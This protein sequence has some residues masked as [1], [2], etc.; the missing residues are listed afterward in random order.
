MGK[1]IKDENLKL[2]IIVNGD[3]GLKELGELN[4]ATR[5]LKDETKDMKAESAKL[6]AAG[7]KNLRNTID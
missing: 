5:K 3:Q 1:V 2:N 6:V 4:N 7:K